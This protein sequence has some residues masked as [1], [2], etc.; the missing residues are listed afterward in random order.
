MVRVTFL[1][2]WKSTLAV[3]IQVRG[4]DYKILH[5]LRWCFRYPTTAT[6]TILTIASHV[7]QKGAG[8]IS[9]WV[10]PLVVL[11]TQPSLFCKLRV[12]DSARLHRHSFACAVFNELSAYRVS[13]PG[14][15]TH[16][17][18]LSC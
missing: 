16:S 3:A 15:L 17:V 1:R 12:S 8:L 2:R 5:V 9:Y 4:H 11:L 18:C 13:R 14:L 7:T 10:W 6:T